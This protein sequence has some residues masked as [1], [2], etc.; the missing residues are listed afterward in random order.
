MTNQSK[1][2]MIQQV[3]NKFEALRPP[4]SLGLVRVWYLGNISRIRECAPMDWFPAH[5]SNQ[6]KDETLF[7]GIWCQ[8]TEG[9]AAK[10]APISYWPIGSRTLVSLLAVLRTRGSQNGSVNPS[11]Q[12]VGTKRVK[13]DYYF[14]SLKYPKH[15]LCVPSGLQG[16]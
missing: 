2:H 14:S 9:H 10:G 11:I 3:V 12:L 4:E 15:V 16:L 8:Q 1:N 6:W 7:R 5:L 13:S